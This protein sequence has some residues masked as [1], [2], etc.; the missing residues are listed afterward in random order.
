[1][2]NVSDAHGTIRVE[3]VA[4]EFLEYLKAVQG[5]EEDAYYKLCEVHEFMGIIPNSTNNISFDFSACGR[6]NYGNNLR[7]YLEGSWMRDLPEKKA[8]DNFIAALVKKKGRVI[9][10]Y[11]DR[12][13]Y[14]WSGSGIA[15]LEGTEGGPI[16]ED[17]FDEWK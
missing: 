15:I 4:K 13:G 2:A 14:D 9:I 10:E 5:K 12:D 11:Q 7:G 6:W 17:S 16:F 8:Y 1:M 3:K